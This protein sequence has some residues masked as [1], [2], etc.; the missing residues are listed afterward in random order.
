V[1]TVDD[2]RLAEEIAQSTK[3]VGSVANNLQVDP[4]V[5]ATGTGG[6]QAGN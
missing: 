1:P 2:K 5:Q 6:P 3:G 4:K